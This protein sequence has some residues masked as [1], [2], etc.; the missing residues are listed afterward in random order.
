MAFISVIVCDILVYIL[1]IIFLFFFISV[2]EMSLGSWPVETRILPR[3]T[4]LI[5]TRSGLSIALSDLGTSSDEEKED[6]EYQLSELPPQ[7]V[8][9]PVR[10]VLGLVY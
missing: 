8:R 2:Y 10:M 1:F 5:T 9:V 3:R 6:V 7:L 4:I